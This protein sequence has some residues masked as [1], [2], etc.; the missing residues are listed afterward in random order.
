MRRIARFVILV[1]IL[2]LSLTL[3]CSAHSGKTDSNGGHYNYSTGDYHYHHGY[4]AHDHCDMD[5]DGNVDCP[6]SFD[7]KTE[8]NSGDI[9]DSPSTIVTTTTVP[10]S[11]IRFQEIR[12]KYD[13]T[14][15]NESCTTTTATITTTTI[16]TT[17]AAD[18]ENDKP[19]D[20]GII[21]IIVALAIIGV[22]LSYMMFSEIISSIIGYIVQKRKIDTSK[23]TKQSDD[24]NDSVCSN[25]ITERARNIGYPHILPPQ[26]TEDVK[27]NYREPSY[28]KYCLNGSEIYTDEEKIFVKKYNSLVR[29]LQAEED[30]LRKLNASLGDSSLR[31]FSNSKMIAIK[32][33]EDR[34]E[35][36]TQEIEAMESIPCMK[37]IF[38]NER[39][40]TLGMNKKD[41]YYIMERKRR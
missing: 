22:P 18:I 40:N 38:I 28:I 16:Y 1:S 39:Y 14:G 32:S 31:V 19:F 13:L 26:T 9:V 6:Y 27:V 10:D 34:I 2:L 11:W 36:L 3:V 35:K 15:G 4:S 8:E 23:C 25:E 30:A 33:A 5:G 41:T 20:W 21:V 37:V 12:E 24:S 29:R 17:I 7:N